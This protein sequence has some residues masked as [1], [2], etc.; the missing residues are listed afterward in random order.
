MDELEKHIGGYLSY[1]QNMKIAEKYIREYFSQKGLPSECIEK[2]INYLKTL[3][4]NI[5]DLDK[6]INDAAN[7]FRTFECSNKDKN[8]DCC[9]SMWGTWDSL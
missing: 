5:N 6:Q 4:S 7:R 1:G 9:F 3:S 2:S 8:S